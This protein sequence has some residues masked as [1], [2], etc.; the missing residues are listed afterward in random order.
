VRLCFCFQTSIVKCTIL[1]GCHF[2]WSFRTFHRVVL[3]HHAF[4]HKLLNGDF[5]AFSLC[6]NQRSAH[7]FLGEH[8]PLN[9]L[10]RFVCCLFCF[11]LK[12]YQTIHV[13][14]W[15]RVGALGKL[16]GCDKNF[17]QLLTILQK[18]FLSFFFYFLPSSIN[19]ILF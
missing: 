12:R 11:P 6:Q 19:F 18:V 13:R 3:T 16:T 9:V 2:H 8:G 17:V 4:A 5:M 10:G 1:I 15:L 14:G 7:C